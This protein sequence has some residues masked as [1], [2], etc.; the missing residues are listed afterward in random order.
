MEPQRFDDIAKSIAHGM[1]RR[2]MLALLGTITLAGC[3]GKSD[4]RPTTQPLITPTAPLGPTATTIT[5]SIF[6]DGIEC[7]GATQLCGDVCVDLRFDPN[8]CGDCGVPCM[9]GVCQDGLC[10]PPA[11]ATMPP[12]EAC[13]DDK[14]TRCG[15][16]C[17]DL[18]SDGSHCGDCD[19]RPCDSGACLDGSCLQPTC[20]NY[21]SGR[22]VDVQTDPNN[23]GDCGVVCSAEVRME[24][25]DGVCKPVVDKTTGNV[26]VAPGP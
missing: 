11:T 4:P 3:G 1:S 21:C 19:A 23:C 17:V 25:V 14:P 6:D 5:S 12:V 18:Q 20:L 26:T 24:C 16:V 8:N 9:S 10:L 7:S 15:D 13:P 22:C 2:R